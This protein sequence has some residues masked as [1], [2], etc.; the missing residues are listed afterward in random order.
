MDG[1]AMRQQCARAIATGCLDRFF[2]RVEHLVSLSD[3]ER[4]AL[5][6]T[7]T[8][9][10]CIPPHHE[11]IRQGEPA[12][13]LR[14]M[15]SGF[16]CR[17]KMLP[18]GRRQIIGYLV[19][20]DAFDVRATVLGMIDHNIGTVSACE[21]AS[22]PRHALL[23]HGLRDALRLLHFLDNAI[24]AEW[25]INVGQRSALE[26]I[27]HLLC[28]TFF[29]LRAVG[30]TDGNECDFPLSQGEL[31]DT[32][33]LSSVHVNRTLMELRH[34]RLLTLRNR[35]LLISDLPALQ[36]ISGFDPSYLQLRSPYQAS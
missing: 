8:N 6:A 34:G 20:G 4:V 17:Y 12:E 35:R 7:V 15:I 26:R 32:L 14:V 22:L 13:A 33:A 16:A 19:P 10:A 25:L 5:V 18:T 28:E 30:L 31:A 21:T 3:A 1:T 2:L 24:T 11:I 36:D 9:T 27:G 29:R 23:D